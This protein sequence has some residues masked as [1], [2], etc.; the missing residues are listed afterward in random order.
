MFEPSTKVALW[1]A[2]IPTIFLQMICI[3]KNVARRIFSPLLATFSSKIL[4]SSNS[5]QELSVNFS[6]LCLDF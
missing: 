1:F 3:F 5:L 6:V 4:F 2:M